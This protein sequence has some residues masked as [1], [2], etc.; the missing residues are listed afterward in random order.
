MSYS[1]IKPFKETDRLDFIVKYNHQMGL[2]IVETEEAIWALS[3]NEMVENGVIKLNP[4]Y[5]TENQINNIEIKL[6]NIQTKLNDLDLKSIRA[7]REGGENSDG[8]PYL[9]YYQTQINE[10]RLQYTNLVS[11]KLTLAGGLND[12]TN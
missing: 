1:L 4:S 8:V 3:P 7:L 9:E 10:L 5:E 2:K 12:I 6:Q 11:E